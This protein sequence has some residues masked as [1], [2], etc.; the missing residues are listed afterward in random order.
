MKKRF[1]LATVLFTLVIL[2][3][4]LQ[5]SRADGEWRDTFADTSQIESSVDVIQVTDTTGDFGKSFTLY[6]DN[7]LLTLESSDPWDADGDVLRQVPAAVHPDVLYFPSGMDGYEFWMIYTPFGEVPPGGSGTPD[8]YWERMTLVRSH[9]GIN[10]EKTDD[11]T[12]P[13][14]SPGASGE[15]DSGWHADPDFVYAPGKGPAGEDWFLYY[16]GCPG[17]GSGCQIALAL[18]HDGKNYTKYNDPT[19]DGPFTDSDPVN[20]AYRCPAVIYDDE[21][22]IFHMWYNWGAFD[23]GYATSPDGINWTPYNPISPGTWG[24]LVFQGTPGTFDQGG[25]TH[26]DVIY[27]AGQYWMYY[28]AK[29]TPAY[30]GLVVGLATSPNGINWTQH[31]DPIVTPSGQT[32]RWT[33]G[34]T[35]PVQTLYRPSA[36]IVALRCGSSPMTEA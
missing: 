6:P 36:A 25:V 29:P 9:D 15:W 33:D 17:A 20:E 10:W 27:H 5:S 22:D 18:S 16:T 26:M 30:A 4:V 7:P 31:P 12:N 32:W 1:T 2:L 34:G 13:L 21:D 19:T 8:W 24:Y 11:Y 35:R 3:S 28:L 14:V 23:I